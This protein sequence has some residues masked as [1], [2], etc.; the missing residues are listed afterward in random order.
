MAD[1][2]NNDGVVDTGEGIFKKIIQ[3]F[4]V[5]LDGNAQPEGA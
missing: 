1:K 3:K 5:D 4:N 2:D